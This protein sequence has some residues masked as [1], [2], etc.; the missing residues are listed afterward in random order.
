MVNLNK[1]ITL[2]KNAPP[3]APTTPAGPVWACCTSTIGPVCEHRRVPFDGT[4]FTAYE[5]AGLER[6]CMLALQAH[7]SRRT[8][9]RNGLRRNNL[10]ALADAL[11]FAY[12]TV[13]HRSVPQLGEHAARE[14]RA[15]KAHG[16]RVLGATH[17]TDAWRTP[18]HGGEGRWM[19]AQRARRSA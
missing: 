18:Q 14:D 9:T 6:N 4:G 7:F 1:G 2:A 11:G 13:S 5:A 8:R 17:W 15:A 3:A 12:R 10:Q 19:R 16:G